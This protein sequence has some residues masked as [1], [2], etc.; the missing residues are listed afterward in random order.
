MGCPRSGTTLI[1]GI[2]AS[3]SN[4]HSLPQTHFFS[5]TLPKLGNQYLHP[6]KIMDKTEISMA[7]EIMASMTGYTANIDPK[8]IKQKH[9]AKEVFCKIIESFRE[10]DQLQSFWVEKTPSHALHMDVIRDYFTDAKFVGIVRHPVE[11]VGS[12]LS[13]DPTSYKDTRVPYLHSVKSHCSQW[14]SINKTLLAEEHKKDTFLLKYED[15][16]NNPADV[17]K[18]VCRFL[19]VDFEKNM[20]NQFGDN[21][22]KFVK[23][24]YSPWQNDSTKNKIYNRNSKWRTRLS[25]GKIELIGH[26]TASVAQDY[27]YSDVERK[28]KLSGWG[29]RFLD[30]SR[31]GLKRF[32]F[33][34]LIRKIIAVYKG[35]FGD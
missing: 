29:E 14:R 32:N 8:W 5:T 3:H 25:Q 35:G 24:S 4:F 34:K 20:L 31:R 28:L 2:I 11:V 30:F 26:Y 10:K 13:L 6:D 1:Q 18:E 12:M 23:S 16:V 21:A 19:E 27:G 9:T 15:L 17:V 7:I 33:E 22:K